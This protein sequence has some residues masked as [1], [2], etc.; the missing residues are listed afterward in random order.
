MLYDVMAGS[1][2]THMRRMLDDAMLRVHDRRQRMVDEALEQ[3]LAVVTRKE[4]L[5]QPAKRDKFA[6]AVC[7]IVVV[8][9]RAVANE[10]ISPDAQM[11]AL[12]G[13][14]RRFSATGLVPRGFKL[15]PSRIFPGLKSL[16][17]TRIGREERDR[18]VKALYLMHGR[19]I[20]K[21]PADVG[22][23]S[24]VSQ[25]VTL[26]PAAF[27][28]VH[29]PLCA[30]LV[31]IAFNQGLLLKHGKDSSA[32]TVTNLEEIMLLE[33]NQEQDYH[34]T[35]LKRCV[36]KLFGRRDFDS[37]GA[38]RNCAKFE[39]GERQGSS[40]TNADALR[41][42]GRHVYNAVRAQKQFDKQID[43][44]VALYYVLSQQPDETGAFKRQ[45]GK[46][47][48]T[49]LTTPRGGLKT[50]A[51]GVNLNYRETIDKRLSNLRERNRMLESY[52]P[53]ADN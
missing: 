3:V 31:D 19:P 23:S 27:F 33:N 38:I 53:N 50:S 10:G 47:G 20:R 28:T 26:N 43:R 51:G 15:D 36:Y 52:F 21:H 5:A 45:Q 39:V 7:R 12:L 41:R 42:A 14:I 44:N 29:A 17:M 18:I 24:V 30:M 16:S 40:C 22:V 25:G 46:L 6:Q 34:R 8:Y 11:Q 37:I 32:I 9:A 49:K 48:I 13:M 1:L 2:R 35:V 4:E